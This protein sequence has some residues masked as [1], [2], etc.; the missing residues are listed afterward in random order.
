MCLLELKPGLVRR[1]ARGAQLQ[2]MLVLALLGGP[3]LTGWAQAPATAPH[4]LLAVTNSMSMGG[5]LSG[6]IMTGSGSAELLT[7]AGYTGYSSDSLIRSSSPQFFTIPDGF[8][9]P[10][11]TGTAGQASYTVSSTDNAAC[12]KTTLGGNNFCDNSPSRLNLAKSSIRSVLKN[13]GN[14]LN[15]GLYSYAASTSTV[16]PSWLYYISPPEGFSFT[17]TPSAPGASP[18]T[19]LNP[20]FNHT[21]GSPDVNTACTAIATHYPDVDIGAFTYVNVETTSD[22]P[23][24]NSVM[25]TLAQPPVILTFGGPTPGDPYVAYNLAGYN[26]GAVM[27]TYTTSLPNGIPYAFVPSNAGYVNYS[28]E[29]LFAQRG[30]RYYAPASDV[31]ATSGNSVVPM[32]SAP[33]AFDSALQPMT[34]DPGSPELKAIA[35]QSPI[36]GLMQGAGSYL[37]QLPKPGGSCQRQFVVLLTDGLPTLDLAGLRWPPLGSI[38][39]NGYGVTATFSATT[40]ALVTTNDHALSDTIDAIGKLNQANPPIQTFVIGLGAA[41][42]AANNPAAVATLQAMAVAGGTN[43][44]YP[45]IDPTSLAAAFLNIANQIYLSTYLAAPITPINVSKGNSFQY[46]PTNQVGLG[47]A[48]VFA[49]PL[50]ADGVPGKVAAWDAAVPPQ[51]TAPVPPQTTATARQDKLYST[52]ATGQ[53]VPISSSYMDGAAFNLTATTCLPNLDTLLSVIANPTAPSAAVTGCN[54]AAGRKAGSFL[55]SFSSQNAAQFVDLPSNTQL[56]RAPGY[57]DFALKTK[58][59][60]RVPMLMFRNNDGFL[61]AVNATTGELLWAWTPRSLLGQM[62]YYDTFVGKNYFDGNFTVVDAQD[63]SQSSDQQWSSYV[64]GSAQS[65]AQHFSLKLSPQGYPAS[66]VYD[67]VVTGGTAPG[68]LAGTAGTTPLRQFPQIAFLPHDCPKPNACNVDTY[69]TYVVNQ[70]TTSRLYEVNVATGSPTTASALLPLPSKVTMSSVLNYNPREQMIWLGTNQGTIWTGPITGKV[71]QDAAAL[72]QATSLVNASTNQPS[73]VPV[74]YTGSYNNNGIAYLYTISGSQVTVYY[75]T[76]SGWTPVWATTPGAGYVYGTSGFEKSDKVQA[77]IA[78]SVVSDYP[79]QNGS[80]F[81]LPVYVP[82]GTMCSAGL[83]YQQYFNLPSGAF[84]SPG[85]LNGSAVTDRTLIGAGRSY[86]ASYSV[87]GSGQNINIGN[88]VPPVRRAPRTTRP[89]GWRLY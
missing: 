60:G 74:L 79:Y 64:V 6:A 31:S 84:Q 71:A 16:Y 12:P 24:I 67:Q 39:G 30:Y 35:G 78:G 87:G 23:M 80:L 81:V 82:S 51:M 86:Q 77:L 45:A 28:P 62:Q 89:Q 58:N 37:T 14:T 22:D 5:L 34:Y 76:A 11:N 15:F 72:V 27:E 2:K 48:N 59:S 50:D 54:Y 83:G 88:N 52:N 70:G 68:D 61:Y 36:A 20:C 65:G 57:L 53:I 42:T 41:L 17:N 69:V 1:L 26:T 47:T 13:Y 21:L 63:R 19:V 38:P 25:S 18:H 10:L 56:T 29:V 9:P 43:S 55:S 32:G 49:F 8:T 75:V 44:F 40:K 7:N 73:A 85:T 66:I 4:V 46:V 3:L 33:S